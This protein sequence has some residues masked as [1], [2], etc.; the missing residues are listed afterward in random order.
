MPHPV[1]ERVARLLVPGIAVTAT[2]GDILRAQRDRS[3]SAPPE[4]REQA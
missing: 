3:L 2:D 1:L 4:A